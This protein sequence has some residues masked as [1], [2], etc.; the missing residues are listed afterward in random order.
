MQQ[1]RKRSVHRKGRGGKLATI[2]QLHEDSGV[3]PSSIRD[4]ILRGLVPHVRL[5][6]GRVIWVAWSDW[7]GYLERSQESGVR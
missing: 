1:A 4:V 2:R 6:G 5:G 7:D 3:P